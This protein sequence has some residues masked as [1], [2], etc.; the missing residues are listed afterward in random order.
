MS[1]TFRTPEKTQGRKRAATYHYK[2][3]TPYRNV[4]VRHY[5]LSLSRIDTGSSSSAAEIRKRP[6]SKISEKRKRTKT[7]KKRRVDGRG[8]LTDTDSEWETKSE[9]T[10]VKETL[11]DLS[12]SSSRNIHEERYDDAPVACCNLFEDPA[13]PEKVRHEPIVYESQVESPILQSSRRLR[14][15]PAK[16]NIVQHKKLLPVS[17]LQLSRTRD[18]IPEEEEKEKDDD[19]PIFHCERD[20]RTY[21][22]PPKRKKSPEQRPKNFTFRLRFPTATSDLLWD[23]FVEKFRDE[24]SQYLAPPSART[25]VELTDSAR[26]LP[27][28]SRLRRRIDPIPRGMKRVRERSDAVSRRWEPCSDSERENDSEGENVERRNELE[29]ERE[30][31]RNARKR[32]RAPATRSV[33]KRSADVYDQIDETDVEFETSGRDKKRISLREFCRKQKV[34]KARARP[35]SSRSDAR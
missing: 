6:R 27:D 2:S 30:R 1:Q 13:S 26:G 29:I 35:T 14:L 19:M 4:P 17:N 24:V 11:T 7:V 3:S 33:Q 21:S 16:D 25:P 10:L 22:A 8:Q 23:E 12:R 31:G 5:S 28:V 15:I 9:G 20:I 18:F 34:D 32:R